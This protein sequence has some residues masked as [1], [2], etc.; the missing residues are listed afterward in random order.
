[1]C[2]CVCSSSLGE[3]NPDRGSDGRV[4]PTIELNLLP[5]P[6]AAHPFNHSAETMVT[7]R[8][9]RVVV[10]YINL[11]FDSASDFTLADEADFRKQAAVAVSTD[12]G[13]TYS[14]AR[15][16]GH[17]MSTDPVVRLAA[18]GTLWASTID[19]SFVDHA[20]WRVDLWRSPDLGQSFTR[21]LHEG[22][23]ADKGWLALDDVDGSA[24]LA[25]V[26]GYYKVS[27]A[28]NVLA[29]H[30]NGS[31]VLD[32]YTDP[33][34]AHF[35]TESFQARLWDGSADPTAEGS[36]LS[37]GKGDG[38]PLYCAAMGPTAD[39]GQW[40][41]RTIWTS[42]ATL[43]VVLRVRHLPEDAG[44]DRPIGPE[45]SFYPAGALDGEGRLHLA[46]YESAGVHGVLKYARS[47][48]ADLTLGFCEPRMID[49]DA[50]PGG[51]WLPEFDTASGGRRLREYI[52]VAVDGRR[53]HIAWTHAP[54]APSRVRT[55]YVDF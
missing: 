44:T 23:D 13:V 45:A 34:G 5:D 48:S 50:C 49:A 35:L 39:G 25:D 37:T 16:L 54:A 52:G 3:E 31:R 8:A 36:A 14:E 2:L 46:W 43:Q 55:M 40:I 33:A 24:Y 19:S 28:G 27:F 12:R 53:A 42:S 51:G 26:T 20:E 17:P 22:P 32:A 29:T 38:Y 21:L 11:H 6:D 47:L 30:S 18:D 15:P 10:T 7:A 41:A 4:G 9:G 1:M